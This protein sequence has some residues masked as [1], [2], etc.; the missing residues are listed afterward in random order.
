MVVTVIAVG[1]MQV[2][3]HQVIDVI[4]VRYCWMPT[5]RAMG[6]VSV[7]ALAVVSDATLRV[8]ARD[9]DD[10]LVVMAFVSAVK[11]S[12]VQVSHVVSV[13]DG[14]VAAVRAVFMVVVFVDFVSHVVY[15]QFLVVDCMVEDVP[16]KRF[17][18]AICQ[19]V[20]HVP[21]LAPAFQ[22]IL[23]QEDLEAL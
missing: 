6:M 7:V 18:M 12:V 8:G 15:L 4:T 16:D 11:V 13:L 19:A 1:M 2:P 5:V 22:E 3:I 14:D 10:V 21:T 9:L 20:E 17:D 23:A